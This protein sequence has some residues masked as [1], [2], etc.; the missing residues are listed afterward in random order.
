MVQ[1]TKDYA[2][3]SPAVNPVTVLAANYDG[4]PI[5]ADQPLLGAYY[6]P[7][8][9]G[10]LFVSVCCT[11]N[12]ADIF[13]E[14][15]DGGNNFVTP[16]GHP[17]GLTDPQLVTWQSAITPSD[18]WDFHLHQAGLKYRVLVLFVQAVP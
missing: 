11:G 12:I 18:S 5:V 1:D 14:T 8:A 6:T 7:P 3:S 4:V 10:M 17:T 15:Y 2:L 16:N 9:P 13:E